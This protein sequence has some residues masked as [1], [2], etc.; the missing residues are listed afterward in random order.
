[1]KQCFANGHDDAFA[2]LKTSFLKWQLPVELIDE[3]A[4]RHIP[5]SFEKGALVFCEGNAD[6]LIACILTG[7][8]KVY[9]AV[10]DGNR[11]LLRIAGPGDIVGYPDFIDD[12]GRH[13]R[14][15]EAQ[16]ASKC[17]V[18]LFSREHLASFLGNLPAA[19]L[20]RIIQTLNTVW[21]QNLQLFVT[22][23]TLSFTDRLRLVL[24]DLALRAGVRDAEGIILIPEFGHEDLA[25]MIGC[26]RPMVSRMLSEMTD[27]RLIARRGKQFVLLENWDFGCM[28]FLDRSADVEPVRVPVQGPAMRPRPKSSVPTNY[29]R[30]GAQRRIA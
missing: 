28:K 6:G 7:Y 11:T 19:E 23:L 24:S 1:M 4:E 21:S 8:V 12:K 3:I 29:Q 22:L 2:L 14:L 15:F 20:V 9:C 30:Y 25:E 16:A 10:G 17:V 18:A 5:I 13:A 26:S 27:L